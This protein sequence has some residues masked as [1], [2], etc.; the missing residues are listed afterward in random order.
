MRPAPPRRVEEMTI[1]IEEMLTD[2]QMDNFRVRTATASDEELD[3]ARG[4]I[5]LLCDKA[6]QEDDTHRL[7]ELLL[8][9]G[10]VCVAMKRRNR[11]QGHDTP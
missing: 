8:M 6:E 11:Y 5:R 1:T 3:H 7:Q 9:L 10:I 4:E 2:E